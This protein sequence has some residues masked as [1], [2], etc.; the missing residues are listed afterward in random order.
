MITNLAEGM[1]DE[2]LSHAA[3]AAFAGAAAGDLRR[4]VERF[5]EALAPRGWIRA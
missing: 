4:V 2:P 5:C 1:A 3:D